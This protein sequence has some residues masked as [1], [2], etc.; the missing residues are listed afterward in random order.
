MTGRST[1]G[2]L[3]AVALLIT[4]GIPAVSAEDVALDTVAVEKIDLY[5]LAVDEA[6]AGNYTAAMTYIDEALAIDGNFTL[7]WITKAGISSAQRDYAGALVAGEAAIALNENQTE[8]WVVSADAL[9]NL[10]RYEEAVA[11][12]E[13]AIALD[14][15]MIE[16]YIIQGTA[17]GQMG[18]YEKE[19]AVSERALEI[20]PSDI[21]AQGNLHFAQAN[22]GT[23]S[24]PTQTPFPVAGAV[25]G[26]GVLFL[27]SRCG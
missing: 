10:G 20:N 4:A 1:I 18:E 27:M 13:K 24:E 22:A 5:N 15:E 6:G 26:A 7:A 16:S 25:L 11:A 21:R 19:I 8:A 3:I 17:Y 9:V 23:G 2:I 12:A 14:P